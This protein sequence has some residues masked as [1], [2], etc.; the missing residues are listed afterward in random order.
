MTLTTKENN[1]DIH[2]Y[3]KALSYIGLVSAIQETTGVTRDECRDALEIELHYL[4]IDGEADE[5]QL[6]SILAGEL[7]EE[8]LDAV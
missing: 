6:L 5:I 7:N 8:E 3:I 1:M 4:L 2:K